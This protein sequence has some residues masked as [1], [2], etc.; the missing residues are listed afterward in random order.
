VVLCV[1]SLQFPFRAIRLFCVSTTEFT[2]GH[3]TKASS[4]D[5]AAQ[6]PVFVT[7]LREQGATVQLQT[8]PGG[9]GWQGDPFGMI[10][11][12]VQW[13]EQQ[14]DSGRDKLE[15]TLPKAKP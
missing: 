12:G 15:L 8:Y 13:L 1:K 4:S 14:A 2:G 5:R 6:Q 10:R 3:A 11:Q 7:T 9:H